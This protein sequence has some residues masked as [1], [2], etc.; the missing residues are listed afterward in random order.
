MNEG[1]GAASPRSLVPVLDDVLLANNY[2][3]ITSIIAT[4]TL[5]D[6][7]SGDIFSRMGAEEYVK[8]EISRNDIFE[9]DMIYY[10]EKKTVYVTYRSAGGIK[11]DRICRIDF[12]K[13]KPV[14]T[15]SDK[16]QPNCLGL[17][18]NV[19][20]VSEP[21]YGADDGYIF[22]LDRSDF[23]VGGNAYK[24]EFRTPYID[25]GRGNALVAEIN[26]N[27]DHIELIY[28][29]TGD[30]TLK[31][32]YYID[33]RY[34]GTLEFNLKGNSELDSME[35]NDTIEGRLATQA[36]LSEKQPLPGSGRRISLHFYNEE[37]AE[38]FIVNGVNIF[39]RESGTQQSDKS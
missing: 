5:G 18:K 4:D 38:S 8:E 3:S 17:M 14:I 36:Q 21:F 29:P 16:D 15:W 34:Q 7:K 22:L 2:G 12:R 27:F 24:G 30:F 1:F 20:K 26:K 11:N 32:D 31:C 39:W 28:E 10:G 35:L 23:N 6:I 9:R 33:L 19:N 25:F 13:E 37:N